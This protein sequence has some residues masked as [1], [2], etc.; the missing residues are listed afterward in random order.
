MP[1]VRPDDDGAAEAAGPNPFADALALDQRVL[2]T[3]AQALGWQ[4]TV[5]GISPNVARLFQEYRNAH[6][7]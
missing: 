5:R 7:R 1:I 4:P 3:R 6:S 2:S